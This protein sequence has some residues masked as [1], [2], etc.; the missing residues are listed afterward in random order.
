ML[1]TAASIRK[2][3][4]MGPLEFMQRLVALVLR[5]RLHL[6]RFDGV[7]ALNA[8]LRPLAVPQGPEK[9]EQAAEAAAGGACAAETVQSRVHRIG[10]ARL[11]KRVSATT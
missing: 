4:L 1:A 8:K 3:L 2:H 10:W 11:L 7:L 9:E 5:P 6:I